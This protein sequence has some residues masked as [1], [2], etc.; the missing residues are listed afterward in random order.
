[1]KIIFNIY[2]KRICQKQRTHIKLTI[3]SIE[4]SMLAANMF[5]SIKTRRH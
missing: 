2:Y 4:I 3:N 5:P 1:M